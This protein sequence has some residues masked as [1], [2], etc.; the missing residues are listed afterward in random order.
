[1]IM[2]LYER[3][4]Y[5]NQCY[6]HVAGSHVQFRRTAAQLPVGRWARLAQKEDRT[7]MRCAK[8]IEF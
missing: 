3:R 7:G 1:M 5:L 6:R 2:A 4:R 8:R